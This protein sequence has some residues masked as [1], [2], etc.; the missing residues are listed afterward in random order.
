MYRSSYGS[1]LEQG[2]GNFVTTTGTYPWE[3][4]PGGYAQPQ[5]AAPNSITSPGSSFS[6]ARL[7]ARATGPRTVIDN[8]HVNLPL[9]KKRRI[10]LSEEG[11]HNTTIRQLRLCCVQ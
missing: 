11:A 5:V 4:G 8:N 9:V 3:P 6:V 2:W 1:R 7:M 10:R